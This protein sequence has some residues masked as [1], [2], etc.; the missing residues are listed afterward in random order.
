MKRQTG[1]AVILLSGGLDSATAAAVAKNDGL[2]LY[3]MTFSYGQRHS[4]E[5]G[6]ARKIALFFGAADHVFIDIPSGVFR[7]ALLKNS[8]AG[9]PKNRSLDESSIPDTYVPARNIIFLSYALAYGESIGARDIYIGANAVDYS[10]Y[11]DCR[12]SFFESF[13]AMANAGTRAGI[14]GSPFVIHTP[15]ISLKKS[16][17]IRLGMSLGVDYSITH[18]CYD[19]DAS[20]V[21][22]GTCDSCC[23]RKM[24]FDEAGFDDPIPYRL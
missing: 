8:P 11:P 13:T 22:C 4:I 1:K 17:I 10:G 5:I 16:E 14:E 23:L 21:S 6:C 3:A 20:G 18:S 9:V 15:L 7:S 12:P 19:P 2:D 24:G